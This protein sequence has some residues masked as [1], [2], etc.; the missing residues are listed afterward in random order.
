SDAHVTLA[1]LAA[2]GVLALAAL[3]WIYAGGLTY[4]HGEPIRS[5]GESYYVYLPAVLPD[6]DVAFVRTAERSVGGGPANSSGVPAGPRH[7]AA[8]GTR[9]PLDRQGVGV[10]ILQL[11]FFL[12]GHALAVVAGERRDGFSW[13]YQAAAVAAGLAYALLGLALLASVLRR[14]F[15]RATVVV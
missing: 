4:Y 14:W 3:A 5:D 15:S 1:V 6:H 10:A 11:P 12:A 9:R 7:G 8:A 2:V 13:P